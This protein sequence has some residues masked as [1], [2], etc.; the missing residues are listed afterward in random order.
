MVT[1]QT[2]QSCKI[3]ATSTAFICPTSHPLRIFAVT[4]MEDTAVTAEV[5]LRSRVISLRIAAPAPLLTTFFTGQP[6]FKS[7]KSGPK[8][9]TSLVASAIIIGSDPRVVFKE[10]NYAL[11]L[12][13][14]PR[15]PGM[16]RGDLL[17]DNG[18]IFVGQGKALNDV[19]D[20]NVKVIVVGN[21]CNTNCLIAMHHAPKI[22]H[23]RGLYP[24]SRSATRGYKEKGAGSGDPAPHLNTCLSRLRREKHATRK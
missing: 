5:I 21:P 17:N 13:A 9:C 18:K 19:A 23:N 22:P 7:M 12:G 6:K 1:A 10:A 4:G 16:E 3:L 2:P 15:G 8:P 24:E 14:K 11:L 20:P